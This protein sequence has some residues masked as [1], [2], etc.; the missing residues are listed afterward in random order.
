MIWPV[1]SISVVVFGVFASLRQR[2][3]RRKKQNIEMYYNNLLEIRDKGDAAPDTDAFI[4]ILKELKRLRSKAMRSLAEKKLDP[5]ESFNVFLALYNEVR[6]D[7][8]E[9]IREMRLKEKESE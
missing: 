8:S 9:K 3:K 2:L 7:M 4:E 6:D 5:G 1:I